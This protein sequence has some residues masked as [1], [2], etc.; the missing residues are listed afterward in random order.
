MIP[1]LKYI[2][3]MLRF[4]TK[5]SEKYLRAYMKWALKTKKDI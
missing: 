3:I 5:R 1:I 4:W 2:G